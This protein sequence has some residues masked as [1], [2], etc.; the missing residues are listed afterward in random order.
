MS[1]AVSVAAYRIV[2]ESLTNARRHAPGAAVRVSLD[3]GSNHLSLTVHSGTPAAP[4]G[5]AHASGVGIEGMRERAL[6]TGGSLRAAPTQDGF[7]VH[8]ELPY[9]PR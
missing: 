6:A 1:E 9:R 5:K 3:Y 7:L 2:Q 4:N 8:A